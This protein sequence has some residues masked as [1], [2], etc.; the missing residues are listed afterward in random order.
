VTVA[1]DTSTAVPA[2]A[3]PSRKPGS[4]VSPVIR[5][6]LVFG[7]AAIVAF[8]LGS[9]FAIAEQASLWLAAT[10]VV[11]LAAGLVSRGW[12][13]LP[14]LLVGLFVGRLVELQMRFG[15]GPLPAE[16]LTGDVALYLAAVATAAAGYVVAVLLLQVIRRR[17]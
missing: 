7:A 8:Y 13:G 5:H 2:P 12:L 9:S 17:R 16:A 10:G 15:A 6:L 4:M 3:T 1:A 11:G 14:F